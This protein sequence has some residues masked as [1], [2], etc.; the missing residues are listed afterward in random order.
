MAFRGW[1]RDSLRGVLSSRAPGVGGGAVPG[2]AVPGG[3]VPGG[4][5]GGAVD[6]RSVRGYS[7]VEVDG[8]VFDSKLEAVCYRQMRG[9]GLI[10]TLKPCYE[11]LP[12]FTFNGEAVRAW[13]HTPDFLLDMHGTGIIVEV[14][15]YADARYALKLKMLKSLLSRDT[16]KG[17]R[18][19]FVHLQRDVPVFFGWLGRYGQT[20]DMAVLDCLSERFG[21]PDSEQVRAGRRRKA[22]M[23]AEVARGVAQAG[24]ARAASV[25]G[26]GV[27][28]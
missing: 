24:V 15:G 5:V 7:K 28:P 19:L 1:D 4:A 8:I 26:K 2:G 6:N 23:R 13:T 22:G 3:A 18:I 20:G 25:S 21:H 27:L 17:W 10:F 16:T 9:Q 14:K 12:A 11:L